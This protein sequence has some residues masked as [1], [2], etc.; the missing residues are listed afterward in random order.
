[1]A[2]PR[3]LASSKSS[4][5]KTY[6]CKPAAAACAARELARLPV[7]AQATMRKPNSR[8]LFTATAT[9]R[10][11]KE[12]VGEFTE[13]FLIHRFRQPSAFPRRGART[14]GVNPTA[15]LHVGSCSRGNR[16]RYR[17]MVGG[18]EA[19]VSR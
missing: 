9:T 2:E 7:D 14:S 3:I 5:I 17:Q 4:G 12:S 13:S 8:A 1:M 18:P 15:K 6:D 11:L 16:S 10:S 19:I